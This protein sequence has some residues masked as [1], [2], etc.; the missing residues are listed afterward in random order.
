MFVFIGINVNVAVTTGSFLGKWLCGEIQNIVNE[1]GWWYLVCLFCWNYARLKSI[2]TH[3]V[4]LDH[5]HKVRHVRRWPI[6]VVVGRVVKYSA[7]HLYWIRCCI[8]EAT[9]VISINGLHLAIPAGVMKIFY[10]IFANPKINA[11]HIWRAINGSMV[12]VSFKWC[13]FLWIQKRS[14]ILHFFV[15]M[16]SLINPLSDFFFHFLSF[17]WSINRTRL[18]IQHPNWHRFFTSS[19]RIWLRSSW[20]EWWTTN[21]IRFLSIQY[22]TW[23]TMQFS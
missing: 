10:H 3:N 15:L 22:A 20:C 12:Q 7:V 5:S 16:W 6:I 9:N 11:I 21:W 23:L 17:R 13:T 4:Y 18:T 8:F 14:K 2:V 1:L 19:S